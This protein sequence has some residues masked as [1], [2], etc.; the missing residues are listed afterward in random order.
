MEISGPPPPQRKII[1]KESL[2]ITFILDEGILRSG[3]KNPVL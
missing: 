2:D 3:V 1:D